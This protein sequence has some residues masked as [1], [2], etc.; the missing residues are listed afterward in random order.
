MDT[1][2]QWL[3]AAQAADRLGIQVRTLYAYVSRGLIRSHPVPGPGRASRYERAEVE[4][5]AARTRPAGGRGGALEVVIDTGLT[6]LDPAGQLYYRGWDATSACRTAS[7][8]RVAE[9]LWLGPPAGGTGAAEAG[10]NATDEPPTWTARPETLAAVREAMEHV[11]AGATAVDRMRVGAAVAGMTDPLRHDRR[12]EAVAMTGRS[13]VSALVDALPRVGPYLEGEP[14]PVL[15]LPEGPRRPESVAARLWSRISS[16]RPRPGEVPALNA[17]LVLLADHELAA[18]TLGARVAAST[19]AD[20]YL[21]VQTGLGVLG[22]PLHGANV[23]LAR[24]FLAEVTRGRPAAE[25]VGRRL[26]SGE[27]IPGLGHAVYRG[28]DPRYGALMRTLEEAHPPARPWRAVQEVLAVL[29]ERRLAAPNVDL[30]IAAL[31]ACLGLEEGAGQA[32][33][34]VARC[35]GWLGH[36]IEEYP[37]RLRFRPRAIYVGLPAGS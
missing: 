14:T 22:G 29:A 27:H 17:A 5:L 19:W 4:R 24:A 34:A 37:H 25:A 11:P 8:E 36:A 18:S 32:V 2:A 26:A 21:V 16:R 12:A 30:A 6:L 20:P 1:G 31:C 10:A 13:L 35:A 15:V 28:P 33:F 9:W 3:S 23:E 7:F